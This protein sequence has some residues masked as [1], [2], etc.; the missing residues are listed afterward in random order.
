MI[1]FGFHFW[2]SLRKPVMC[3]FGTVICLTA[4]L[5]WIKSYFQC[6]SSIVLYRYLNKV[7]IT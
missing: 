5:N 2:F 4:I 3:I 6:K 1:F 7:I